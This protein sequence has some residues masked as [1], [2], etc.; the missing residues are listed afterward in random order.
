MKVLHHYKIV[1]VA[2]I[3]KQAETSGRNFLRNVHS[4]ISCILPHIVYVPHYFEE[5]S[6]YATGHDRGKEK[7]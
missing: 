1:R 7:T 6:F 5:H 4:Q 3:I 2:Q